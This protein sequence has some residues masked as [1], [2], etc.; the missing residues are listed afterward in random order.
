MLFFEK[1]TWIILNFLAF[2]WTGNGN[3]S[4]PLATLMLD[5]VTVS[6]SRKE[7]SLQFFIYLGSDNSEFE[8]SYFSVALVSNDTIHGHRGICSLDCKILESESA[9]VNRRSCHFETSNISSWLWP[10]KLDLWTSNGPIHSIPVGLLKIPCLEE[11]QP[12]TD[13][14]NLHSN[15]WFVDPERWRISYMSVYQE[16][17]TSAALLN[18]LA[19]SD[20]IEA[21]TDQ[22]DSRRTEPFHRRD[23]IESDP[24]APEDDLEGAP[25][26]PSPVAG[27]G[28]PAGRPDLPVYVL[29][30]RRRRD[31]R[32]HTRALLRAAGLG[33]VRF[34]QITEAG[35]VDAEALV[36]GGYVRPE[37]R[38]PPP[39]PPPPP[40]RCPLRRPS[41]SPAVP[42]AAQIRRRR[43]LY[44]ARAA[45]R[46]G[47]SLACAV[48]GW[49]RSRSGAL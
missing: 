33:D 48:A 21:N 45:A 44:V 41:P 39:P 49:R 36:A 13:R 42:P 43:K 17:A 4:H 2:A 38:A 31:R 15:E 34:P 27:G 28:G 19:P 12:Q 35:D 11:E 5:S 40:P 26:P 29:N 9:S 18:S 25:S 37:V 46:A 14:M 23:A 10:L 8:C 24:D 22:C 3:V 20:P 30:L 47:A 1:L 32:E 16:L 7:I 6:C